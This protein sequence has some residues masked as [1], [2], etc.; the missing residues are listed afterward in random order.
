MTKCGR[1]KF[2]YTKELQVKTIEQ[3]TR[4]IQCINDVQ[5]N[6]LYMK[7]GKIKLEKDNVFISDPKLKCNMLTLLKN[8]YVF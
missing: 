5:R 7:D 1:V 8:E 3:F 6:I 2:K 4:T